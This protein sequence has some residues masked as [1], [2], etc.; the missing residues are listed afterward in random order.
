VHELEPKLIII[1]ELVVSTSPKLQYW[2]QLYMALM[3]FSL[4][5]L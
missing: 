1:M 2:F 4:L 5:W 3:K